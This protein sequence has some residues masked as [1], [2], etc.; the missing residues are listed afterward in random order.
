MMKQHP[1]TPKHL[2]LDDTPYFITAAIYQKR[3]LMAA[4]TFLLYNP[5]KHGYVSDLRNYVT[6]NFHEAFKAFGRDGLAEQF[7]TYSE[8]KTLRITEALDDDF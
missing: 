7:R 6:S 5:V 1:H 2:F 8:Y 3:R 4:K